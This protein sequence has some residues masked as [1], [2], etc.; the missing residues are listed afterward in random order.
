MIKRMAGVWLGALLAGQAWGNSLTVSGLCDGEGGRSIAARGRYAPLEALTLGASI[1]HSR[2]RFADS[3]EEFSGNTIG[4]A[5]D[6]SLGAFFAGASADRWKD[7]GQLR[8]TTLHGEAGWMSN[9]GVA[10]A[11]L[12]TNR[13]MRV[14]YTNTVLGVTRERQI[15]FKGTGFGAD[16]SY[17][18]EAWTAGVAFLSYD[19]GQNV[20][21]VRS[22]LEAG[23][24]Q[25]FPRLQQ[26]IGSV[27]TRAA[28]AP[29]RELSLAL[30]RQFTHLSLQASVQWQR[31]ALT[32]EKSRSAGLT[33]G[34]SPWKHFGVDLSAGASKG[35][36][37]DTI[38][39][40]GLALTLRGAKQ[41]P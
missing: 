23:N 36:E 32:A 13:A 11:A 40:V 39:W 17:Y 28:G 5:A 7:S 24:T 37:T 33:L 31:D 20:Q 1:G 15:D 26:L 22:V 6:L 21:R 8:S 16:L 10:L 19:Y 12:V 30:G 4:A 35:D 27:A 2:A 29:D 38:G 41:A 18:G 34:L 14:T 9:A 25:R 3:D